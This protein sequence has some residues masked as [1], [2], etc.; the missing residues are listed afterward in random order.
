MTLKDQVK[1]N[2]FTKYFYE[3]KRQLD[4]VSNRLETIQKQNTELLYANIFRDSIQDSEWVKIRSFSPFQAAANYSLLYKLFKIYDVLQPKSVLEFGLGQ[5]TRLTAQYAASNQKCKVMAID[6]SKEWID[7]YNSQ[8]VSTPNL[9][10]THLPVGDLR[11][12]KVT[13]KD[14]EY[15]GLDKIVGKTKFNLVIVDGPIGHLKKYSRTNVVHL[16]DNLAKDWVVIFDD[17]ERNGEKNTIE[18]FKNE[19]INRKRE[20]VNFEFSA[21]KSQHYFCSPSIGSIVHDI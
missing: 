20:Y 13:S 17:A 15:S 7:I 21:L 19:L 5:T 14:A 9:T 6:S 1:K 16:I 3:S 18:L 11:L 10:I 12:G 4:D 8:L 2:P